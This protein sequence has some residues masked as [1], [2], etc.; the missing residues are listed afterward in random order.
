ML[1]DIR[2]RGADG[3]GQVADLDRAAGEHVQDL[4]PSRTGKGLEDLG[5]EDRDLVHGLTIDICAGADECRSALAA[6]A[7]SHELFGP[8]G[9]D[10]DAAGR[11]F[12]VDIDG[13]GIADISTWFGVGPTGKE[14]SDQARV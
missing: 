8:V 14:I 7:T 10:S 2:L 6:G 3:D 13:D 12:D 1:G 9:V 5:L 4:E 11:L